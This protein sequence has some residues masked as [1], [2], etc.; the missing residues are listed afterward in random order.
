MKVSIEI[1][2]HEQGLADEDLLIKAIR[3]ATLAVKQVRPSMTAQVA[4]ANHGTGGDLQAMDDLSVRMAA[5]YEARVQRM[6]NDVA[7][8]LSEPRPRG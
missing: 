6:L 8:V 7:D 4:A 1:G 2:E 3:G 5:A